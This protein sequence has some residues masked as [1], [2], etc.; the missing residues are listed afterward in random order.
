M[1]S[2]EAMADACAKA[3]AVSSFRFDM[4]AP[5]RN[6]AEALRQRLAIIADEKSRGDPQS[7]VERLREISERIEEISRALPRPMNPQLAH[8]LTR[9]SYDK[10][11]KLLC[12]GGL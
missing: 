2:R 7:H 10:A 6:L 4:T 5:E 9:R 12:S 3:A 11:L 8:Y 1:R